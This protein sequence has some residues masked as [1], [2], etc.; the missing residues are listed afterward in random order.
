M[1]IRTLVLSGGGGRG[2]FHAGVYKY[3]CEAQKHGVDAAHQGVWSPEIVVG[4]SIGAVNGAAIAQGISARELEHF[5]LGLREYH[6]QGLPPGMGIL[7][8][9]FANWVFKRSLGVRLPQ[10]PV[11]QGISPPA[12]ESWPPVPFLPN[13]LA[14]RLIGRWSNILDTA[15]LRDTLRTRLGLDESA[16][17]A[18]ERILLINATNVRTGEG[19]IFSNREFP[20]R[21]FGFRSEYVQVGVT[22]KRIVASC[23]IPLMYP[24]TKDDDG[25]LYWDGALVANTPLGAAF[26]AVAD[27]PIEE[28][29]EIVI[30]LLNPWWEQHDTYIAR[31]GRLP[32]DFT[33]AATWALDWTMLASFRVSLKMLRAFNE[34]SQRQVANGAPQDYRRVTEV[35]VAPDDFLPVARILDYD[36]PA[37]RQL[38]DLGYAAAQKAFQ[39]RFPAG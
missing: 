11:G 31:R 20:R 37:S 15:P 18:A 7:A 19:V 39:S 2:A 24:W 10:V 3:L 34:M 6:V 29:M 32:E 30:V 25:E 36:E 5:W 23:S 17:S 22:L 33:E 14:D 9:W 26:D 12:D 35:M 13:W 38:I 4:T 8:R 16:L 27:R 1:T 21:D 28:E